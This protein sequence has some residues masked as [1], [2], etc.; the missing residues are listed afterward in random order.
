MSTFAR[1]FLFVNIRL[2]GMKLDHHAAGDFDA[3]RIDPPVILRQEG[4]DHRADILG[5]FAQN[6]VFL[7][8]LESCFAGKSVRTRTLVCESEHFLPFRLVV[9]V[10]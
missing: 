1:P 6:P 9:S 10:R 3:L 4:G 8:R 5:Q 7:A 2:G